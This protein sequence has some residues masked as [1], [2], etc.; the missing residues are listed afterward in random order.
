MSQKSAGS[1]PTGA[2]KKATGSKKRK[3]IIGSVVGI[4]TLLVVVPIVAFAVAYSRAM[5]PSP[6]EL[7]TKQIALI[8]ASDSSTEL[9]RIVPPEGNRQEVP[10][11]QVPLGAQH[12]IL[13]AEDREFYENSG[14][15]FTGFARAAIGQITG[16]A[17]AGG[18]STITQQYVK[19]ALV[20]NDYSYARKAKE[21][22]YSVKMANQWSKEE[23]LHAY[24]NTIYFGRNAYGIQAA[25]Q[26]YFGV[27]AQQLTVEQSAV[28]AASIQR[29]SQ[30]EPWTNR[31]EAEQRWNYVL[32]GMAQQGW[33]SAAERAAM[34][35]PDTTDPALNRAYT[36]ADGTNGLI[37][38]QV[39]AELNSV[40]ITEEDVETRGLK[41]TTTIDM[42]AQNATMDAVNT[43]LASQ[44]D[45][46]RV[47]T[48]S[49][50][51][52][53]GAVR[54][55]YGGEDPNGWDFANAPLQ[56]GSTFKIVG[57]A[58][59]VAQ[60]IP[61]STNYD[62][63]P[64]QL[65]GGIRVTNVNGSGCGYCSIKQALL[66]SYNTSFL[67]LQTDLENTTQD[68]ADM[69]HLL[70]IPVELPGYGL[71]L[72]ENGEQ[73]YDGIILG[74][75]EV[76]TLD[77]AH[78]MAT[79]AAEGIYHDV[80]F[81]ERVET[82]EGEVL[83]EH[84]AS[85]GER[86]I[87]SYVATNVLDAMAPI[88]GYSSGNDLAGGRPSATKTGTAQLGD[89]GYNKDAWMVGGTPQLVTAVWAGTSDN[90]PLL[91][92]WGGNM[93]GAN[94]P[95]TIWKQTLDG[96]LA[97]EPVEYFTPAE[98]L[99]EIKSGLNNGLPYAPAPPRRTQAETTVEQPAPEAP[100]PPPVEAP[101]EQPP[102]EVPPEIQQL[103]P[104]FTI[105]TDL[106][107]PAL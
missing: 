6:S 62:S 17:S 16:N 22:V 38:S 82:A 89:T 35:Y 105:P 56:T 39:M 106:F 52:R 61:T 107:P 40:G 32:D 1:A 30:L 57:L 86:R 59:A 75:Y 48:V 4:L 50:D 100:A 77:M 58:A 7:T 103:F 76:R 11:D 84:A 41:V 70:G 34:V 78:L 12:A 26:A 68:T 37:K 9:A 104:E 90:S 49:V 46:V 28:L 20:G 91:T 54:A 24:L 43:N 18:G 98:P 47:A 25:A 101:V 21:L 19:N 36:E 92:P 51:P 64:F 31:V 79:L 96:A 44:N 95:A 88:A 3:I 69:G 72:R 45:N 85:E 5:V 53:S 73:P 74:Q 97:G 8:M 67:R 93:Y 65:P 14:F 94:L 23:V 81:V 80:Y 71:T 99:P 10:L 102:V 33:L 42:K 29:P 63:S 55:Y 27:D 60:G 2:K 15:S 13:A 87:E 66:H 83:Y